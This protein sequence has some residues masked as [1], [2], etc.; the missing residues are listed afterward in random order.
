M[1]DFE[2]LKSVQAYSSK[3]DRKKPKQ[4]LPAVLT[5]GEGEELPVEGEGRQRRR[6]WWWWHRHV[7]RRGCLFLMNGPERM[8]SA[9]ERRKGRVVNLNAFIHAHVTQ[10][11]GFYG[12]LIHLPFIH[13]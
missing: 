12:S 2:Y 4:V 11:Y 3:T 6:R 5:V 9:L 1:A 8:V 10:T 13:S 7:S